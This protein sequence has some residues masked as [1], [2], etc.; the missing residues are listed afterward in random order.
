MK[1]TP[2]V[3]F[4]N[5][6]D[7]PSKQTTYKQTDKL[8]NKEVTLPIEI[9]LYFFI[10]FI[11]NFLTGNGG[12]HLDADLRL[13]GAGGGGEVG[14]EAGGQDR[15]NKILSEVNLDKRAGPAGSL[16]NQ[17][18]HHHAINPGIS[19]YSTIHRTIYLFT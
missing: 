12:S 9:V 17:L 7:G 10:N 11:I 1:V 15:I 8:I 3:F 16:F 19:I 13:G 4:G 5:Y 6:E 2:H 14:G 18:E